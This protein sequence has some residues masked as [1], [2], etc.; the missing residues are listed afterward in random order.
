MLTKMLKFSVCDVCLIIFL[1]MIIP[2]LIYEGSTSM[3]K[4]IIL[5]VG[6]VLVDF[7]WEQALRDLGL[8]EE[9]L[10]KVSR[11]TVKSKDWNEF[12]R[13]VLSDEEI[14]KTFIANA[15]EYETEIR[16][17]WEHMADLVKPYP[18][19]EEFV[20]N[21]KE[22]GYR[23]YILSNYPRPLYEVTQDTLKCTSYADGRLFS[24]M[25]GLTKPEKEIYEHL[26]ASYQ[27]NAEECLFLDDNA[28]N[29][30]AAEKLG[31]HAIR[32]TTLEEA[33]DKM[34]ELGVNIM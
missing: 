12:D 20:K 30:K 34:R 15:P 33:M 27:L 1:R 11:A 9:C 13:G 5:D 8:T 10:E 22:S 18:Y 17:M 29:V 21:L 16:L 25:V 2:L 6:M 24:H 28:A 14:L 31:I 3:I 23:V 7:C 26:L 32:F 4:N 19:A